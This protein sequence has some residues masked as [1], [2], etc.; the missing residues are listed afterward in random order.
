M[1]VGRKNNMTME[2]RA[3]RA[4]EPPWRHLIALAAIFFA[5][6]ASLFSQ[7][8]PLWG[9]LIPGPCT[10]GF[11]TRSV[12]D[13]SR[14]FRP[15]KH[16]DGAAVTGE[17][18]RPVQVS[19][20]YPSLPP[21]KGGRMKF[22]TY[23]QL[24]VHEE[25]FSPRTAGDKAL[26]RDLFA[27]SVE[28]WLREIPSE[29]GTGDLPAMETAAFSD[30]TPAK[31]TY[32]LVLFAQGSSQS[33]FTHSV[34]C[35]YV[36][37][38]GFVVVTVPSE[39]PMSREMPGEPRGAEGQ[40]RD[41]EFARAIVRDMHLSDENNLAVVGFS[42]GG[43]ASLI[44][45]MR[46]PD[47]KV[48]VSLD[49]NLGFQGGAGFIGLSAEFDVER[50]RIP[51]LH[52]SQYDFPGL[53]EGLIDSLRYSDRTLIRVRGLTHF[54]FSSLGMI[55]AMVPGFV[56]TTRPGQREGYETVCRYVVAF[57]VNH[58]GGN[59]DGVRGQQADFTPGS[60]GLLTIRNKK[61]EIA[62][63]P[64]EEFVNLIRSKG[65]GPA[66]TLYER[67]KQISPRDTLFA[68][69]TL[70]R[71]G[72]ELLYDYRLTGEAIEVFRWNA[73]AYPGS[74]NVYDSLGEAYLAHGEKD[75]A[76]A[77][78]RKSLELNPQNTNAKSVLEAI[79]PK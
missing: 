67:E 42:F 56:K 5:G 66:R 23:M 79:G 37:S 50:M 44:E 35:E 60:R 24:L 7:T 17:R 31:G 58:L 73:E 28:R 6:G 54:D 27:R 26:A 72:Y 68:E 29:A 71:M 20:W 18:S 46:D 14:T 12:Y 41:L 33:S 25:N 3:R 10:V 61:A 38:Y 70:N 59:A 76:I 53:E 9:N 45:A 16:A 19:V 13:Y 4:N 32:P 57:L 11:R 74:S 78:Y 43:F 36:A 69:R 49:S 21:K 15:Q 1:N 22:E 39:G 2:F 8:P 48:L 40:A 64:Y 47:V 52:F 65:I 62:A 75:R 34:L 63:A 51:L 55:T 30:A 77:N